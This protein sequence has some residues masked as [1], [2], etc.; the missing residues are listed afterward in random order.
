MNPF[1]AVILGIVQGL[2]EFLPISSSA[3]VQ[4]AQQLLGL[5]AMPKPQL[6]AFI[7]T[8]QLGTE[9]AVLIYFWK[10]IT[11]IVRAFFGSLFNKSVQNQDQKRDAKLGWLIIVGSV[12]VVVVGLIFK[13]AIENQLRSLWVIAFTLIIFG[14]VL[15]I[16]DFYGKRQKSIEQ[17]TTRH[18]I[19]FGLGQA[20]AVIPGV[21]RS[22]GTISVGLFLGYSRQAAA[23]YSF[24]LAIPA[25]I[26]S[27]LYEFIKTAND[28]D[29]SLLI[30][31]AVATI[32]SF[33]VGFSVIVGLLK[34]L[35]KGSFMPFVIWRVAVGTLLIILLSNNVLNA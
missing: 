9:A 35:S 32:V 31:T 27:G 2:T 33:A 10:D 4:I 29:Q 30:A 1:E 5:G 17:L 12:P 7:A 3:H 15:G 22:G 8:I 24:L 20:L 6:T 21:S 19:L 11:R 16:A 14:I 26:A 25:V 18:G 28:L 13:D 23:R 34:Y